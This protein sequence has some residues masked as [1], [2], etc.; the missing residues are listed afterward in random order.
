MSA[1]PRAAMTTAVTLTVMVTA[2]GAREAQ[3]R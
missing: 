3:A 2:A 1:V